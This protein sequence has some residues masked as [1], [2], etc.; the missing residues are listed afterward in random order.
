MSEEN[1]IRIL[2]REDN[3]DRGFFDRLQDFRY[4]QGEIAVEELKERLTGFLESMN[5]VVQY[6]PAKMGEFR[7]D[8]VTLTVEVSATGKVSLLGTGGELGGKGG[9]TFTLKRIEPDQESIH[10][11]GR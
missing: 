6:L 1:T 11:S 4:G 8:T 2:G 5:G 10:K 3:E 7:L 9:L